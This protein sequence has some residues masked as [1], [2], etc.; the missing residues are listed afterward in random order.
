LFEIFTRE[1]PI[2]FPG[3]SFGPDL[4]P[5]RAPGYNQAQKPQFLPDVTGLSW[6]EREIEV[7]NPIWHFSTLRNEVNSVQSERL[8]R[9]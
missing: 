3:P 1:S 8:A 2:P 7:L 9:S 5:R 4:D 6:L